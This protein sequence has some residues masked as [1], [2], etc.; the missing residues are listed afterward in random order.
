MAVYGDMLCA[1]PELFREFDYYVMTP[2]NV[3]SYRQRDTVKKVRGV[4]QHMKRGEL[5]REGDTLSDVDV[6]TFWTR[7][8]LDTV[9]GYIKHEG[10]LYHITN[11]ASWLYEGGFYCYTMTTV[12]GNTGEQVKHPYVDLG[13]DSYA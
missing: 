3:A 6:P 8:R 4:F 2:K 5:R 11:N 12:V 10:E 9:N 1:F 13:Q 7:E